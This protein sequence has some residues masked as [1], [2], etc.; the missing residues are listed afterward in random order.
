MVRLYILPSHKVGFSTS[1]DF[2]NLTNPDCSLLWVQS[3][4]SY[5]F[6]L[7]KL[8]QSCLPTLP[9]SKSDF[10]LP[11]TPKSLLM[12]LLTLP[13]S[14]LYFRLWLTSKSSY[15]FKF[16]DFTN[17]EVEFQTSADFKKLI[18]P[19]LLTY[20]SD[21]RWLQKFNWSEFADFTNFEVVFQTFV[22]I[23]I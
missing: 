23:E 15:Q 7:Y 9:T 1:P 4:I 13:T 5:F 22:D 14:K 10:R 21:F 11:L 2:E 3:R 16:A 20:I 19:N 17:F 6:R 12:L 18:D 8:N